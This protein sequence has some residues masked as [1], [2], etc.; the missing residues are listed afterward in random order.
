VEDED[1]DTDDG[2]EQ[3]PAK[4]PKVKRVA[5]IPITKQKPAPGPKKVS[6]R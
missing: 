1:D 5:T 6:P 3:P 2:E 4:K